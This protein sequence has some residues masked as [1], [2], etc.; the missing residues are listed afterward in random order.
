MWPPTTAYRASALRVRQP[1]T[2]RQLS[3]H[4]RVDL[5]GLARQRREPLHAL[6]VSNQNVPALRLQ[7][8]VDAPRP[9]VLC[10]HK[11]AHR[12]TRRA[13]PLLRT[14]S[15]ATLRAVGRSRACSRRVYARV[16]LCCAGCSGASVRSVSIAAASRM[17]PLTSI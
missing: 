4:A 7:R 6:R 9:G 8:V 1:D 2:P 11:R 17:A 3:Q 12:P 16:W 10:A 13:D 14:T 15:D 5:V